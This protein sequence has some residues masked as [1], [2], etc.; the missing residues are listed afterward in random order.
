MFEGLL[1]DEV[2][3]WVEDGDVEGVAL[4]DLGMRLV[5]ELLEGEGNGRRTSWSGVQIVTS[6]KSS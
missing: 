1:V 2:M 5:S 6:L 3:A 4:W